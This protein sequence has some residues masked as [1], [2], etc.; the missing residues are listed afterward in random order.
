VLLFFLVFLGAGCRKALNPLTL[1]NQ[2]PETWI[3]AAPQDTI[4]LR[5]PQNV[6]IRPRPGK[7]PVRFH[8]YW[9]GSDRDGSVAGF[10]WAVVETSAVPDEGATSVPSLPGPKPRDYH[11]TTQSDSMFV[12]S[13]A[14]EVSEREHAFFIYAVDNKGR[15]DPTPA[16]FVFSAYDRFPPLA[17]IDELKAEG[18]VYRLV[19][20]G[21]G[22]PPVLVPEVWRN[23]L[24]LNTVTDS[25]TPSNQHPVP[26]D[27]VPSGAQ[28]TVRWHGG[29]SLAGTVLTGFRYKLDEPNFNVTG[30]DVQTVSYNTGVGG[31]GVNPG[32]KVFTLR[33]IGQSGWRGESTRWFYMNFAP[34]TW[35][36]GPDTSYLFS[37]ARPDGWRTYQDL[38]R[39][40][41]WYVDAFTTPAAALAFNG[42]SGTLLSRDSLLTLPAERVQRKTFMEVYNGR[43]WLHQEDDT[44]HMNSWVMFAAGGFDK[45]SPYRVKVDVPRLPLPLANVPVLTPAGPNGSPI[46]FHVGITFKDPGGSVSRPSEGPLYPVFNPATGAGDVKINGYASLTSSGRAFVVVRAEDGDGTTDGRIAQRPGDAVGVVE[47]VESGGAEAEDVALRSRILTFYVDRV[48]ALRRDATFRPTTT[49]TLA[50]STFFTMPATDVDQ[51]DLSAGGNV[52]GGTPKYGAIVRRKIA[53][54]GKRASDPSQNACYIIPA[55]FSGVTGNNIGPIVIPDSIAAGAI[56]VRVRLCDCVDCDFSPAPANCPAFQGRETV[57]SHGRCID[58]DIPCQ[59][60]GPSPATLIGGAGYGRPASPNIGAAVNSN[61]STGTRVSPG[62]GSSLA[63]GRRQ[64]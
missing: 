14:E 41:Y 51:L 12:F 60:A 22:Q 44:V 24:G 49:D 56:I 16:R 43:V 26:R 62:P 42:V 37:P 8:M 11:Y 25:F 3:V 27:T 39:K 35:I 32:S 52:P 4:T 50:R 28:L 47:R 29:A 53:I 10:Y 19:A 48:P 6:P 34:D 30:P 58:I 57:A 45:D 9:A 23:A 17:L 31:D 20:P 5:D 33:A 63:P 59:L 18:T 21:G 15:P 64:Q 55:E 40:R 2:A 7:I 61:R 36:A 1:D 54:I 13:A 38:N 46:G